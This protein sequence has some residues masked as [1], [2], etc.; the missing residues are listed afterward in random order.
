MGTPRGSD[1]QVGVWLIPGSIANV[2]SPSAAAISAGKEVAKEYL[3][4][5]GLNITPTT[6]TRNT[7]TLG[8]D[9]TT[10]KVGRRAFDGSSLAMYRLEPDADDLVWDLMVYRAEM[11]LVIRRGKPA[12][13]AVAAGDEVEVYPIQVGEPS[14]APPVENGN[15]W[16]TVPL[17]VTGVFD[18]RAVVV[19]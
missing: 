12:T 16:Y 14:I 19:I 10:Q 1:G 18:T 5:D 4:P 8:R 9:V 3:T 11:T 15:D 2:S 17:T 6:G 7:S 13:T